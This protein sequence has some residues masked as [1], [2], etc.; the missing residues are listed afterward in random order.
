MIEWPQ[1][2]GMNAIV[3]GALP[4]H[5]TSQVECASLVLTDWM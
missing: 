1:S 5:L 3:E 2:T 4:E